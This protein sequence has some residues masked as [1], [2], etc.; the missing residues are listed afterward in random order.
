[1]SRT[2]HARDVFGPAAA[3]CSLGV[4]LDRFGPRVRDPVRLDW[5][6][7]GRAGRRLV[8]CVLLADR[9]GNLLTNLAQADLPGPAAGCVLEIAGRRIEGIV[10]TYGERPPRGLGAVVDSSGRVEIFVRDGSAQDRLGVAPGA[11]VSLWWRSSP[12]WWKSSPTRT[13]RPSSSPSPTIRRSRRRG[14]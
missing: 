14:R 13:A 6:R 11:A 12:R 4:P 10:G 1:V 3:H 7:P 9:F 8:G 5:P 2:F